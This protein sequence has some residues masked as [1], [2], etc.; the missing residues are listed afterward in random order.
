MRTFLRFFAAAESEAD[1]PDAAV[2]DAGAAAAATGV[3]SMTKS[4]FGAG[5]SLSKLTVSAYVPQH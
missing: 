3:G 4:S 1:L 2:P 5:A